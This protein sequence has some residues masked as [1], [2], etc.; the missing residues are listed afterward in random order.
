M[1]WGRI[2]QSVEALMARQHGLAV[3]FKWDGGTYRGCRSAL[4]KEAVNTTDGLAGDYAFSLLCPY[5]QFAARRPQPRVDKVEV[6]GT[7]YRVLDVEADAIRATLK[8]HL[9]GELS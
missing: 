4:R 8:L 3:E 7:T 2:A 1:E 9:G 6:E 5:S